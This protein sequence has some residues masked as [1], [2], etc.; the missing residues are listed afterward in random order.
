M[1]TVN[2]GVYK[3]AAVVPMLHIY[4]CTH[5]HTRTQMFLIMKRR[6]SVRVQFFRWE[7]G[8]L[9]LVLC[10]LM[11][12]YFFSSKNASPN[13]IERYTFVFAPSLPSFR[14]VCF[15]VANIPSESH[16]GRCTLY[17]GHNDKD[18]RLLAVE[19]SH[20]AWTAPLL[21][22]HNDWAKCW[23]EQEKTAKMLCLYLPNYCI[24][25][26]GYIG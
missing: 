4:N 1:C 23:I 13:E 20:V 6:E 16:A 8:L 25:I 9:C 26:C 10:L 12:P 22:E 5:A 19:Y 18:A 7:L 17:S 15:G 21:P 2:N 14:L 11:R 3:H 24:C